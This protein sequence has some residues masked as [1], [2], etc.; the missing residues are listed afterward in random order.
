MAPVLMMILILDVCVLVNGLDGTV[1]MV[2]YNMQYIQ[3]L[4]LSAL[5][6]GGGVL[7]GFGSLSAQSV[8]T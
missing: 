8:P 3:V 4:E 7:I 1:K 6:L 5:V 2:C